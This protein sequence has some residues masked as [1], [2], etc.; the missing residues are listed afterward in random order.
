VRHVNR[1]VV[2]IVSS[3]AYIIP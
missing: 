2:I 3:L 1:A